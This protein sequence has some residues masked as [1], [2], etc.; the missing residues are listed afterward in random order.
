MIHFSCL[1]RVITS[2][3][4]GI[5]KLAP[6]NGYMTYD[7]GISKQDIRIGTVDNNLPEKEETFSLMLFSPRGGARVEDSGKESRLTGA[8]A[9]PRFHATITKTPLLRARAI[10]RVNFELIATI[11]GSIIIFHQWVNYDKPSS[12]H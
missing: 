3:S 10:V 5:K 4:K 11:I 2:M 7:E 8:H 12:S 1:S 6:I 9:W